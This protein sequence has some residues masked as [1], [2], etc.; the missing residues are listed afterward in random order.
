M[1]NLVNNNGGSLNAVSIVGLDNGVWN[2]ISDSQSFTVNGDL[3]NGEVG[4]DPNNSVNL[5]G[6]G[7]I[8]FGIDHQVVLSVN[9]LFLSASIDLISNPVR[10]GDPDIRFKT[11]GD[12]LN[13]KASLYDLHGRLLKEYHNVEISAGE[14]NLSKANLKSG[15][16]FVKF[17]QEGKQ[18]VKKL[19]VE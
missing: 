4:S 12:V 5:N 2:L 3:L 10:Q 16:Y 15:L 8:T 6:F 13:M 18:G 1:T 7:Q 14:G 9:D 11:T 17:E 19:I